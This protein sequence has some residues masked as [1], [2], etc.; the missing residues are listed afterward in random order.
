[1]KNLHQNTHTSAKYFSLLVGSIIMFAIISFAQTAQS[2]TA[3]KINDGSRITVNGTSNLHA[4]TMTTGSFNSDASLDLKGQQL[5]DISSLS[6]SL[7]VTNLKSKEDLMNTRAYKALKSPQFS[8]ITFRLTQAT[9]V[10]SQRTINATGNLT[11]GGKTNLI[12]IESNYLINGDEI[13]IKGAKSIKMSDFDIKA[14][15]FM[16]GALKTGNEVIIDISLKLKK[17]TITAL[18]KN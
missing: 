8:K 15:S 13:T 5:Q 14:P 18:N 7:P 10:S 1:M 17:S 16:L 2:Q 9:V 3:Y 12:T 4:W 11:I 6:F